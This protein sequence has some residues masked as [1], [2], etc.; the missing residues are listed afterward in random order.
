MHGLPDY[1]RGVDI[2]FQALSDLIVRPR[3]GKADLLYK[4]KVVTA[5]DVTLIGEVYGHGMLYG[6]CVYL[7]ITENQQLSKVL[8]HVDDKEIANKSFN[9]LAIYGLVGEHS[10]GTYMLKYD[11]TNFIYAVGIMPGIT[12]EESFKIYYDEKHLATP[13]VSARVLYALVT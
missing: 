11:Q 7:N 13:E 8:L 5:K 6:G 10:D 9:D 12:F 3:Y 1:Y 2:A 4:D